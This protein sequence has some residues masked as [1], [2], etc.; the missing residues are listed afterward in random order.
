ML[1][2]ILAFQFEWVWERRTQRN[3]EELFVAQETAGSLVTYRSGSR[4]LRL[5]SA[6]ALD[7]RSRRILDAYLNSMMIE[8]DVTHSE[9]EAIYLSN[10]ELIRFVGRDH[11]VLEDRVKTRIVVLSNS[12]R[13]H[14]E[15]LIRSYRPDLIVADGSNYVSF[16]GRWK[17]TCADYGIP[18]H[19]TRDQG[20]FI[21]RP[22]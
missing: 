14:L 9:Q 10:G 19:Y 15:Q 22:G 18:F 8:T 5:G 4:M 16:A 21:Y 11:R 2:M 17:K 1:V 12:P 7:E 13:I 20:A 6:A 3:S